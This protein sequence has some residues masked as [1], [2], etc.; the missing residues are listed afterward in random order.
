MENQ[1]SQDSRINILLVST[2][3][4]IGGVTTA[5]L[6]LLNTLDYSRFNV[7]LLLYN[8]HGPLQ[9][10]I[11]SRVNLLP[12]AQQSGGAGKYL[13]PG[14]IA[15][16]ARAIYL[17]KARKKPAEALQ[18]RAR[19]GAR[20]SRRL[21]KEYD[22]AISFI[23]FWP[24]YY[25]AEFVK[26][27]HKMAWI[28]NDYSMGAINIKYD[29]YAFPFYDRIVLVARECARDFNALDRDYAAKGVF[30]PN[31]VSESLVRGRGA[32]KSDRTLDKGKIRLITVARVTFRQK[33][34]DRAVRAFD[35]LR[36]EGKLEGVIWYIVGDGEDFEKLRSLVN[37]LG[38][39][40]EIILLGSTLSPLPLV[41]QC[42]AFFLPSVFEGKPIAA[43]EA[44]MLGLPLLLTDF[45][46]AHS[47][48]EN[49]VDGLITENSEEGVR[50]GLEKLCETPGLLDELR[51]NTRSR[52]YGNEADIAL[53]Y[54]LWKQMGVFDRS[55]ESAAKR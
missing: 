27:K 28:H 44:Q 17:E 13:S 29:E 16:R 48:V 10:E 1:H 23:E 53:Y 50:R 11:P 39:S 36:R 2:D 3:M 35:S 9:A 21:E 38:R 52:H 7:D 47:V 14:Y 4:H 43:T 42:D 51:E 40:E 55:G 6:A 19:R 24:L 49:G 33:A 5:L 31:I 30:L 41:S 54:D 15:D 18:V 32:Q 46:S 8:H 45:T 22:L 37:E 20:Y 34:Q 26:A 25:V 12:P